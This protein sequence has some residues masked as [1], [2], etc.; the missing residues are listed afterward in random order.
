MKK[1]LCVTG[2]L[3]TA[4]L[5]AAC[6]QPEESAAGGVGAKAMAPAAQAG[7]LKVEPGAVSMC[8]PGTRIVSRISWNVQESSKNQVKVLVTDPDS[9][10][11]KLFTQAGPVGELDT[12][13]WVV[14]GMRFDVVDAS[15]G[16]KIDSYAVKG[17]PCNSQ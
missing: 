13:A 7:A 17:E 3:L 5:L 14:P 8:D 10:N 2:V 12:G 9:T 15:T 1:F 11:A 6:N 16:A 4:C